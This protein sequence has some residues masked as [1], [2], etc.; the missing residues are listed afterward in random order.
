MNTV[1]LK[2][3][4]ILFYSSFALMAYLFTGYDSHKRNRMIEWG[5]FKSIMLPKPWRMFFLYQDKKNG[6]FSGALIIEILGYIEFCGLLIIG[7]VK[8]NDFST[9]LYYWTLAIIPLLAVMAFIDIAVYILK[10]K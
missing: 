9:F 6:I 2:G 3:F 10:K 1:L 4:L 5:V 7:A 8:I